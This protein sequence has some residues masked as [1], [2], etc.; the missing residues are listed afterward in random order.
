MSY[1]ETLAL[2]GFYWVDYAVARCLSVRLSHVVTGRYSVDTAEHILK[3]LLLPGSRT[4]PYQAGWQYSEGNPPNGG[5]ECKGG[6]IKITI[7]DQYLA[8]SRK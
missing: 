5:D 7:F 2:S 3:I 4:V 8:L 1:S 6:M